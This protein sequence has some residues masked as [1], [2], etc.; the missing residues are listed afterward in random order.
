MKIETIPQEDHQVKIEAEF[1]VELFESFKRR[2]AR[3]IAKQA[4]IPGFRPGKAPYDVILR[5]Y[6]E[7]AIN[8]E[9]IELLIDEQYAKVLEEASVTPSGP[10]SLQEIVSMDPPKLSFLVP[11][12]PEV[13]LGDYKEIKLEYNPEPVLDEEIN[14][15][16]TR[17]QKNYA[18]AEPAD[19]PIE[20]GD[21]VYFKLTGFENEE[22]I[23]PETPVQLVMG[24][25]EKKDNWPYEGFSKILMGMSEGDTKD[26]E[27]SFTEE[28]EDERFKGK[29][30]KFVTDIQSVKTLTLPELDDEF[31]NSLGQFENFAELEKAVREQQEEN[32]KQD[33]DDRYYSDL[34]QKYTE[35]S[36]VKFP[37]FMVDEEIEHMLKSLERDLK[38]QNL[39]FDTYLKLMKTDKEKYIEENVRPAAINRVK[40]SLIIDQVGQDEKIEVAKEDIEGIV[41]DTVQMLQNMPNQKGKKGKLDNEMVN[42][43]TY[44]AISR[45]YNQR[46]LERMKALANGEIV[47]VEPEDLA[48]AIVEKAEE[49][50]E[51]E[52]PVETI[53]DEVVESEQ[54]MEAKAEDATEI[55][56]EPDLEVESK[57][58]AQQVDSEGEETPKE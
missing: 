23:L 52:Q 22:I 29:T 36:T 31:A 41:S 35:L 16:L 11:L 7:G 25:D 46:T 17:L 56:V 4:K 33:Y 39:D 32:K 6:G 44:N 26:I 18:T 9:A 34:I 5:M 45:L 28:A 30:I 24:E 38:Q 40:S 53:A 43:V 55:V 58:S 48:E 57:E 51:S 3:K 49:V 42:N 20:K 47:E 8:E 15:F 21:V 12:K 27:Y 13:E 54:P 1:E 14:E 2:A 37:P 19:R 10:G 50:V